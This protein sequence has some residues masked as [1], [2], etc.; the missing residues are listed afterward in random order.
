MGTELGQFLRAWREKTS[1]EDVGLAAGP[2][3]RRTPGLRREEIAMLAGVS[4][5]YYRRL[6]RGTETR[7]SP[8]VANAL[9]RA[10]R[11]NEAELRHLRIL[12]ARADCRVASKVTP[13]R[14]VPP[15]IELM[16]E[17]LRPYPAVVTS[18][19]YD[20]LAANPSGM[21]MLDG[22][23]D[24]PP[25]KRNLARALF[26]QPVARKRCG[27]W[28]IMARG[29]VVRLRRLAATEPPAPDHSGLVRELRALSR[30][31]AE[32]WDRYEVE[33][34]VYG[35]RNFH[36]PEIGEVKMGFQAMEIQ[37]T[38]GHRLL[39]CFAVPG[40]PEHEALLRLDGNIPAA[41]HSFA[42]EQSETAV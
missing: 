20:L 27:D 6:E 38:P 25:E 7:P 26:L 42:A 35:E 3:V 39:Y 23:E 22:I 15:G 18:R 4:T 34:P 41:R 28:E 19:S 9:A 14:S 30:E 8:Q 21:R 2:G 17:S 33:E 11:L 24:L 31:F 37:G 12:V 10:L 13:N 1:P 32:L 16:L 5:G 40:S 36:H 29:C